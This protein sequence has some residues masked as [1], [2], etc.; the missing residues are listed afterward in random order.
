MNQRYSNYPKYKTKR[1]SQYFF[2]TLIK[3]EPHTLEMEKEAI[4]ISI[5]RSAQQMYKTI[6]KV[7]KLLEEFRV[8]IQF[9]V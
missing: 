7:E 8:N 4:A 9:R 6:E 2:G 3:I 5:Q 1:Y